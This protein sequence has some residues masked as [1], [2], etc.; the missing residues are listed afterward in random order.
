MAEDPLAEEPIRRDVL[1]NDL[2]GSMRTECKGAPRN[3]HKK[4]SSSAKLQHCEEMNGK[5][6]TGG[7]EEAPLRVRVLYRPSGRHRQYYG[8]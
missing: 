8:N 2:K 7:R 6:K 3:G 4:Q 5:K 1:T